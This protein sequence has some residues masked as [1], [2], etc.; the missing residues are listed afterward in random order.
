MNS[1]DKGKRGEREAAKAWA[2]TMGCEARRG[3]QYCGLETPD[4]VQE[5]KGLHLE[6]KRTEKFKLYDAMDQ[7]EQDKTPSDKPIV[8]HR[9]N[10]RQWVAII[11]LEDLP[12][13][14]RIIMEHYGQVPD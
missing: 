4:V 6:V 2:K 7:A 14:A 3:Q 1:K 11:N 9:K 5:I 10:L 8:L 12:D 13:V